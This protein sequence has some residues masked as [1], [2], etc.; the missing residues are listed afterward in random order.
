MEGDGCFDGADFEL[1]EGAEGACDCGLACFGVDDEFSD[2]GVVVWGDAVAGRGV[3][4]DADAE[5]SGG[6]VGFDE[7]CAWA[8]VFGVVFGV[9]AA[10]DGVALELDVFLFVGDFFACGDLDGHLY[11]VYTCD[12]FGDWVF[13][14]D[15]GVDLEHVEV[16]IAIHEEL[17]GG[18]AGV[19]C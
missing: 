5:A 6:S 15:S 19:V 14:L 18:G 8:E 1:V 4:V 2:H 13:D 3:G 7:S 10:L 11:D 9:D 12:C 17:D 16:L